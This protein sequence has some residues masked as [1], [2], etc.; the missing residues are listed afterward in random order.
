MVRK[1]A[2]VNI[3]DEAWL[4]ERPL[5]DLFKRCDV[6]RLED[7]INA[8]P[9]AVGKCVSE[10]HRMA[11]DECQIDLSGGN[12]QL[13]QNILHSHAFPQR[14]AEGHTS[15]LLGEVVVKLGVEAEGYRGH[16][17]ILVGREVSSLPEDLSGAKLA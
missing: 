12:S 1:L 2:E 9:V 15:L 4:A 8:D 11:V 3:K 14:M 10:I 5:M 13:V 7:R 6:E 16:A 17:C